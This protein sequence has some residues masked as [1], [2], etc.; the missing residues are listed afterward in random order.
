MKTFG[1][2][3][4]VLD[5][6]IGEERAAAAFYAELAGKAKNPAIRDALLQFSAEERGHEKRLLA[7][8]KGKTLAPAAKAVASLGIADYLVE[9][10]VSADM[11]YDKVLE[12]AMRKEKAA[13]RLYSDLAAAAADPALRDSFLA[14]AQEEAKH[15]LRFEI[16]YDRHVMPEN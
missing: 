4:E 2:V 9:D 5:F 7:V 6:A 1:S 15:K 12:V 10:K 11:P 14:L 8:K 3:D 16:E 13:F